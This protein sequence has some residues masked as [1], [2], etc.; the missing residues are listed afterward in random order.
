MRKT[1]RHYE[2]EGRRFDVEDNPF[3]IG[4]SRDHT[5]KQSVDDNPFVVGSSREKIPTYPSTQHG[6]SS[7]Y[8]MSQ[9]RGKSPSYSVGSFR[10][11]SPSYSSSRGKSLKLYTGSQ[12]MSGKFNASPPRDKSP[13]FNDNPFTIGSSRDKQRN[14][15]PEMD[16][17]PFTI[18]SSREKLQTPLYKSPRSST[19]FTSS[20][21]RSISVSGDGTPLYDES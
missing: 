11:R 8:S 9:S 21:P 18:G 19:Q 2:K 16:D 6:K 10:G 20:S 15:E 5:P 12:N 3:T 1:S 4:S 13:S 17:N 14:E 7:S